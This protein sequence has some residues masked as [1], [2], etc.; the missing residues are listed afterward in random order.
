MWLRIDRDNRR[1]WLFGMRVHHGQAALLLIGL[2]VALLAHDWADF[3]AG[4]P[5]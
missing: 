5:S 3:R 4:F 1:V 2:G